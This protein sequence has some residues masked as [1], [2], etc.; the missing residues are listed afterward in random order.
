MKNYNIKT[1]VVAIGGITKDD[2]PKLLD[3]GVSGIALSS[4]ILK[5]KNPIK[6]MYKIR[7][8]IYNY[9]KY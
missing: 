1:P 8:L 3:I 5:A 6:E 7:E 9:Y 4:S 2:I